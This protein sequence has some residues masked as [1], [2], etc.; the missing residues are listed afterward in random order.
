MAVSPEGFEAIPDAPLPDLKL[1]W[2]GSLDANQLRVEAWLGGRKVGDCDA[3][4]ISRHVV[5]NEHWTMIWGLEVM[6]SHR[7]RGIGRYLM[8]TMLHRLWQEGVDRVVLWVSLSDDGPAAKAMYDQLGFETLD[9]IT[10]YR[11]RLDG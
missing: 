10:S 3:G 4:D 5:P 9:M 7:R 11:R 8:Q 1:R 6:A 2:Q